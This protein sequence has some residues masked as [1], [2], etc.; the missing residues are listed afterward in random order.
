MRD[1]GIRVPSRLVIESS[2]QESGGFEAMREL[3]EGGAAPTAVAVWSVTTAVGALAAARDANLA[4]PDDLSLVAFHDAPIA[5]YLEPAL[6]TV[7]M[8]MAEMAK[9][10]V[11]LVLKLA[12]GEPVA[13]TIVGKPAPVLVRRESTARLGAV[14]SKRA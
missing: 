5:E 13:E 7:R 14:A 3:V 1:A 6:A 2:E 12:A 9:V 8:P 11:G 10:A 4:V